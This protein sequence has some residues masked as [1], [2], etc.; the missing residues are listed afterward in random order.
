MKILKRRIYLRDLHSE[1]FE[2]LEYQ[3][4]IDMI[5]FLNKEAYYYFNYSNR[6]LA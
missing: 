3:L 4:N 6:I 5:K 1:S 2:S